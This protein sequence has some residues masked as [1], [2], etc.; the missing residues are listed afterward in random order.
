[1]NVD[2]TESET[3]SEDESESEDEVESVDKE[4]LGTG[5]AKDQQNMYSSFLI[6]SFGV[7]LVLVVMLGFSF[8]KKRNSKVPLSAQDMTLA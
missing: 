4:V 5:V 2:V 1:V 8:S 3:E 6:S 7:V